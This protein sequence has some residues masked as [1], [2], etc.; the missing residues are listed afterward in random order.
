MYIFMCTISG[1]FLSF[2]F[3][4]GK[5]GTEW[6]SSREWKINACLC[7]F[8]LITK[9]HSVSVYFVCLGCWLCV[10][11]VNYKVFSFHLSRSSLSKWK[12]FIMVSIIVNFIII[13]LFCFFLFTFIIIVIYLD[14]KIDEK[15]II[16]CSKQ[17]TFLSQQPKQT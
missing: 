4:Q 15:Y 8:V 14:T 11:F 10:F 6:E 16:H 12:L 9:Y 5:E 7:L 1:F 2:F 17:F 13:V 3:V